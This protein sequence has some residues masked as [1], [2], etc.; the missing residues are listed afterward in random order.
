MIP[1]WKQKFAL[2]WTGQ[3]LS[4]LSSMISQYAL[5]WYLTD[6][7]GSPAV[8]S[9]ATMAALVPQ[10]ILS[11]FTG[12]FADRFDRRW[13]MI[14]SD[15]AIG[16]VSLMLAAAAFAAPLPVAPILAVAALRSVGGAFH[17][18]CIQAVTP[19]A[20]VLYARIPLAWILLLDTLGA[21]FAIAG[22]QLARL[23]ALRAEAQGRPLRL[24][25]DT[26]EGLAVLRSH[27]WLWE[28]SLICALFSVAFLPVSALFPL[29]SMEYFG[30]DSAAA[31]LVE[32]LFSAGMLAGSV[33]LGLWGGTRN[34]IITMTAAVL[35]LGL[36]LV[37]A[38]LLPPSGFR[39]FAGLS[40]L[41][42]LS[43]PFFNSVF[44]ALIQTK[45]EPEYLGRVLGLTGAIMTLASP[46]G[47]GLTALFADATGVPLWFLLAGVITLTCGGLMF[48]LPSVRTCGRP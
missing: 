21:A 5:I 12:T 18:P 47:L 45:V 9:L 6:L 28:L 35:G 24:W 3:A 20:A 30:G 40:L 8:L 17:A 27:R 39:A 32:T 22:V 33:L 34:K 31:A 41:M 48:L 37:L 46:L 26:R 10:G 13:I 23:P 42:G 19:L 43:A 44:M 4:I 16:L 14:I 2:L 15:G 11:L 25:Q 29:M 36:T 7:T 1:H 38:G